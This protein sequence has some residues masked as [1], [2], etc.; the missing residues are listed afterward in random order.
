MMRGVACA[1]CERMSKLVIECAR[2]AATAEFRLESFF[3]EPPFGQAT[4]NDLHVRQSEV[5]QSRAAFAHAERERM[6]HV[7]SHSLT[8]SR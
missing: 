8:L 3:P 2:R 1:E 5:E 7:H 6:E 4:A